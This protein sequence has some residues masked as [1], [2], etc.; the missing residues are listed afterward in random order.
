MDV[1]K[2]ANTIKNYFINFLKIQNIIIKKLEDYSVNA[3]SNF[4]KDTFIDEKIAFDINRKMSICNYRKYTIY[5]PISN[6]NLKLSIEFWDDKYNERYVDVISNYICLV[7]YILSH[8]KIEKS[9]IKIILINYDGKKLIPNNNI[10]TS[11]NVNSGYS[12][13]YGGIVIYRREEMFK[14]IVHE[15]I[16]NLNFDNKYIT[17]DLELLL[18]KKFCITG[19]LKLNEAFTEAYANLLNSILYTLLSKEWLHRSFNKILINNIKLEHKFSRYQ[20]NKVL[21]QVLYNKNCTSVNPEKTSAISYYVIKSIILEDVTKFCNYLYK[22]D[23]TFDDTNE[24]LKLI[25]N[26]MRPIDFENY[27]KENSLYFKKYNKSM[28]MTFLDIKDLI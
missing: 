10:F 7:I 4:I 13:D 27:G 6:I 24:L 1:F 26:N 12:S 20:A 11:F 23:N 28:R 25:Y 22:H 8:T 5:Q 17:N 16:H 15:L 9:E 18:K 2:F 14:V 21:R 3:K 19:D